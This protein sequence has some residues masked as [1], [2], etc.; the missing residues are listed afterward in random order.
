MKIDEVEARLKEKDPTANSGAKKIR[1]KKGILI[2]SPKSST[3]VPDFMV[4]KALEKAAAAAVTSTSTGLEE[5]TVLDSSCIEE[6]NA[7]EL[8]IIKSLRSACAIT[9]KLLDKK[10]HLKNELSEERSRVTELEEKNRQLEAR[11][12]ELAVELQDQKPTIDQ[13]EKEKHELTLLLQ[14]YQARATQA[15]A[16]NSDL[17]LALK[18][19]L[20]RYGTLEKQQQLEDKHKYK[21]FEKEQDEVKDECEGLKLENEILK[22]KL[23][24]AEESGVSNWQ[25]SPNFL[26]E[27][28][29]TVHSYIWVSLKYNDGLMIYLVCSTNGYLNTLKCELDVIVSCLCSFLLNYLLSVT[30]YDLNIYVCRKI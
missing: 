3:I 7:D 16:A 17:L 8:F 9:E 6:D 18:N 28:I 5:H 4:S 15:E 26:N 13:L 12:K 22:K 24:Q 29:T 11:N 21:K 10:L 2:R 27:V 30:I 19:L 23:L 20:N 1:L 25:Q 14:T